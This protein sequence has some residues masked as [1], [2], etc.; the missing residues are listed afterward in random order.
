MSRRAAQEEAQ[1]TSRASRLAANLVRFSRSE[2]VERLL[3]E[4]MLAL[5]QGVLDNVGVFCP[6]WRLFDEEAADGP[7]FF[8][9]RWGA[10]RPPEMKDMAD[11]G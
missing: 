2:R 9:H 7:G 6:I 1:P 3:L 10:M 8:L 11:P 4:A 5:P